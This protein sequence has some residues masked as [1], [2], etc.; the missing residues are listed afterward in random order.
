M[1]V[2]ND[3]VAGDSVGKTCNLFAHSTRPQMVNR[4]EAL[5]SKLGVSME[6]QTTTFFEL[7]VIIGLANQ[8]KQ[9]IKLQIDLLLHQIPT[10]S[11]RYLFLDTYVYL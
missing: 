1:N 2:A 10:S 9:N 5:S 4:M 3:L 8:R 6:N 7:P 11:S